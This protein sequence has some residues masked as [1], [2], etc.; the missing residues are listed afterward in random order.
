MIDDS[1][2]ANYEAVIQALLRASSYKKGDGGSGDSGGRLIAILGDMLGLGMH[3]KELHRL[4]GENITKN[5][6]TLDLLFTVGELMQK[7]LVPEITI[8]VTSF[9]D[10][11]AAARYYED[12]KQELF[13]DGDV[14]LVKGSRDMHMEKVVSSILIATDLSRAF[15]ESNNEY[16]C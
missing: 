5:F 14:V 15:A 3:E 9:A 13:R 7:Y 8:P 4:L 6:K 10:S 12:K 16:S 2:N 11:G 1:Y